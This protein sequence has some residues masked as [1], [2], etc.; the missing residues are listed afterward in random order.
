MWFLS[1]CGYWQRCLIYPTYR[2][3]FALLCFWPMIFMGSSI[4]L[5]CAG[6]RKWLAADRNHYEK[7]GKIMF[8]EMRRKKQQLSESE[9]SNIFARGTSGVLAILG[10]EGYPYAVPLSYVYDDHK[11][12]FHSA[13][14]GHKIDAI[15]SCSKASFCVNR[16]RPGCARGVYD[17]F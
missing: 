13:K 5:K 7:R 9:C 10:D 2:L 3:L 15:R 4:G 14:A 16:S 11:I 8:R 1:S 6:V 12:Y 17:I